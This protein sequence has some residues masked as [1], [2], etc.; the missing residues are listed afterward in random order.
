M[1]FHPKVEPKDGDRRVVRRFAWTPKEIEGITV[2][3]ETCEVV[4]EYKVYEAVYETPPRSGWVTR[5]WRT[6]NPEYR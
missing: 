5:C 1:R 3:L 2:W 6:Y 4:Q